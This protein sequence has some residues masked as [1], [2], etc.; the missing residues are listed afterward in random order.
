MF[1]PKKQHKYS[2]KKVEVDG[3]TFDSKAEGEYYKYLK[4]LQKAGVVK[5]FSMQVE[6]VL[7][8]KFEHPSTG[9]TV[10]AIKYI[11]D[12]LIAYTDGTSEVVDVKGMMTKD[13]K[14]KAK[15]FMAK[16]QIPLTIA[17]YDYRTGN[18][19]HEYF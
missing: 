7:L 9:K 10:R 12:F 1:K 8:D 2:A 19:V 5:N 4:T 14:L 18:F 6:Y 11:P 16:Y 3:I 17:K 13:F 15:M